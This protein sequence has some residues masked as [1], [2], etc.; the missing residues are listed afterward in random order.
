[1][2]EERSSRSRALSAAEFVVGAA[3]VIGHNVF[4]VV[5]NEVVILFVLGIVSARLRDGGL[6][7]FGLVRPPSWRR[8]LAI[9]LAAA[10]LRLLLGEFVIDPIGEMFWPPSAAP[11]GVD[12]ITGNLGVAALVLL[13]VWTFAAFGEEIAYRGYLLT[14]AVDRLPT[15]AARVSR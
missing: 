6:A 1:M 10:A 13:L 12:Q 14:R 4:R 8:V 5:P 7:A 2:D 15:S 11:E 3:I 9:A